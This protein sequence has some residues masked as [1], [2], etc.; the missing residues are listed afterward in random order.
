MDGDCGKYAIQTNK[1]KATPIKYSCLLLKT[2]ISFLAL[3]SVNILIISQ[4]YELLKFIET[5]VHNLDL[6]NVE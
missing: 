3:W 1:Q 6:K 2:W 4:I 5:L